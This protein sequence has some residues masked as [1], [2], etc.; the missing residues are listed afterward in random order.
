MTP[1][2]ILGVDVGAVRTGIARASSIA[3]LAEPLKTVPTVEATNYLQ[4]MAQQNQLQAIVVG[5]PRSLDGN[6]SEQTKWVREWIKT[7]KSQI[8]ATFYWQDEAL[9]S[10]KAKS[11]KLKA[12]SLM[13][14]HALAASMILQDFL[15]AFDDERKPI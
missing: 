14:E 8:P 15:D 13:D 12:N 5:L 3:K 10:L 1:K 4:K 9:T 6:D 11:L 2:E 7:A